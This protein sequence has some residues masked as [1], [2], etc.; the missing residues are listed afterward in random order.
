MSNQEVT[1]AMREQMEAHNDGTC[2]VDC[3]LHEKDVHQF[4]GLS[5]A[6]WLVLPRAVLQAMPGPRQH[7]LTDLL[8]ELEQATSEADLQ[9]EPPGYHVQAVDEAGKFI[10]WDLPAYR[11][12]PSDMARLAAVWPKYRRGAA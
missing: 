5:Y 9:V 11:Y 4:F 3:P 2:A 8:E 7:R 12:A 1:P 6:S 10:K